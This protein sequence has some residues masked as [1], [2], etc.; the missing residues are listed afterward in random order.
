MT[1]VAAR[2]PL[3]RTLPGRRPL[4]ARS[5]LLPARHTVLLVPGNPG[6]PEYYDGFVATLATRLGSGAS[7]RALGLAGHTAER[8]AHDASRR[9]F[10]LDE[11]LNMVLHAVDACPATERVSLVGHSIGSWLACEAWRR[12]PTR[13]SSVVGI[14]PY[15]ANN[16]RSKTQA[17]L[18]RLCRLRALVA[19]ITA[20][21]A[22]FHALP[23]PVRSALFR[24][25]LKALVG[26]EDSAVDVTLSWLRPASIRNTLLL[27]EEELRRL[28]GPHDWA[29][30]ESLSPC[31][32]FLFGEPGD[33]WAPPHHADAFAERAL[34]VRTDARL[35]HMFPVTQEGSDIAAGHVAELLCDLERAEALRGEQQHVREACGASVI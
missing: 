11:Q 9:V 1:R 29:L 24:R 26:L 18:A 5:S 15:M 35:P 13:V 4:S 17:L 23:R 31:A 12:R 3:L 19:L 16:T 30:L 6:V 8:G 32:A 14:S 25:P 7:V 34:T 21:G 10:S 22:A 33:L 28:A 20:G 2:A 27:G